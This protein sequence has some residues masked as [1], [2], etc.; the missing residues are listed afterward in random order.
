MNISLELF[1]QS[2]GNRD[3]Y[4]ID[5]ESKTVTGM[6]GSNLKEMPVGTPY[7]VAWHAS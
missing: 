6:I 3:E 5:N 2:L 7:Q 1:K 4:Y